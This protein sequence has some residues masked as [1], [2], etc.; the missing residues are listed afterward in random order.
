MPTTET[1]PGD[2]LSTVAAAQVMNRRILIVRD[3]DLYVRF[4]AGLGSPESDPGLTLRNLT[5]TRVANLS[6]VFISLYLCPV[7]SD[8]EDTYVARNVLQ[9]RPVFRM[10]SDV[11]PTDTP[12]DFTGVQS[13][14]WIPACAPMILPVAVPISYTLDVGGFE[15]VA[16]EIRLGSYTPPSDPLTGQDRVIFSI[17]ASS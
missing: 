7:Y 16:V 10:P 5:N 15:S 13:E 12:A 2:G 4:G 14:D 11:L 17:S 6:R 8:G 1:N 9:W 3:A